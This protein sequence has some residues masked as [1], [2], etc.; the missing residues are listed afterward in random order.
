MACGSSDSVAGGRSDTVGCSEPCRQLRVTPGH[1]LCASRQ[2]AHCSHNTTPLLSSSETSAATEAVNVLSCA[3]KTVNVCKTRVETVSVSFVHTTSILHQQN[4]TNETYK[5][6]R[7]KYILNNSKTVIWS[8]HCLIV[9]KSGLLGL[10]AVWLGN[11]FSMFRR[12][13]H[14]FRRQAYESI[15]GHTT[16]NTALQRAFHS[17][18]GGHFTALQR[19]FHSRPPAKADGFLFSTF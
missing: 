19:A 18:T 4:P 12:N 3:V 2:R 17:T 15:Q 6:I 16:H 10:C 11:F 8:S 13:V 9:E 14:C 7:T 1:R 5:V